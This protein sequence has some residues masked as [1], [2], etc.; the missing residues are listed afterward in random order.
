MCWKFIRCCKSNFSEMTWFSVT[1]LHADIQRYGNFM[2][3]C[4]YPGKCESALSTAGAEFNSNSIERRHYKSACRYR[5]QI[6][7]NHSCRNCADGIQVLVRTTAREAEWS[8][9]SDEE[10][11]CS[12]P[13]RLCCQRARLCQKIYR[14]KEGNFADDVQCKLMWAVGQFV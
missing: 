13:E 4:P 1:C 10:V 9:R 8:D 14:G 12:L 5:Q 6:V 11:I 2:E 7:R 3:N